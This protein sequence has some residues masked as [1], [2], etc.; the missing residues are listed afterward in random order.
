MARSAAGSI[1][2]G[3]IRVAVPGFAEPQCG[4]VRPQL[5]SSAA[6]RLEDGEVTVHHPSSSAAGCRAGQMISSHLGE[7]VERV[8]DDR[9]AAVTILE[10]R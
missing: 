10:S 6:H 9:V 8:R 1:R 7:H 5:L 4:Q 3:A 2:A